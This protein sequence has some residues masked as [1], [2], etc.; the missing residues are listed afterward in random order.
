MLLNQ[1]DLIVFDDIL[2]KRLKDIALNS[3][4]IIKKKTVNLMIIKIKDNYKYCENVHRKY[5]SDEV[6]F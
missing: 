2:Q 1:L 4:F 3:T 6:K 5:I